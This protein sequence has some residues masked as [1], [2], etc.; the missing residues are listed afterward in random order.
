MRRFSFLTTLLAGLAFTVSCS[1][2]DD[3]PDPVTPTPEPDANVVEITPSSNGVG[4]TTWDSDSVYIL[5]GFI[6]VNE[7]Q[8]LTIEPG[9]VIKGQTGQGSSASALIVARG[10][11]II[12]NGTSTDPIIFTAESDPLDGTFDAAATQQW[13]GLIILGRATTNNQDSPEKLVEGIT[14]ES[15]RGLYGGS[16]DSDNSGTL[17]Y[18]SIRHGGSLLG[19]A[20]EINGLTLGAVGNGTTIENI[21]VWSNFDDGIEMFGGTVNLKNVAVSWAGDDAIDY[22]EGYRGKLQNV[23]VWTVTS[24]LQ[25]DDPRAGEHDGGVSA[26]ERLQ[27]Y[28]IP[29]FYNATYLMDSDDPTASITNTIIFRDN[30]GGKYFN[31]IFYG[32]DGSVEVEDLAENP[33]SYTRFESG[34]LEFSNNLLYDINGV[35]DNANIEDIFTLSGAPEAGN[36]STWKAY[37]A[38]NNMVADPGF[39]SGVDAIVPSASEVTSDLATVPSDGFFSNQ[40]YKGAFQPGQTPWIANW[41]KAWEVLNQ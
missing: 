25:S 1:D 37:G 18:V 6:F 4:T 38:N 30:A 28:A 10:G 39:G 19:D 35:T 41:T 21:E 33:D 36:E 29:T 12:A 5:R 24:Q 31:S 8:T 16:D 2:D 15:G 23:F 40:Q 13:G 14:D 32:Y 22:D 17:R 7:N 9:T 34:D 11:T 27:P 20:N 3:T 26:N